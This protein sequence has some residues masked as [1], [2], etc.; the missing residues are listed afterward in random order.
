MASST[1]LLDLDLD[2][3]EQIISHLLNEGIE[4]MISLSLVSRRMR[5][6]ALP[7]V[8]RSVQW[9]KDR[10]Q[11]IP[12]AL[13]PYIKKLELMYKSDST[14]K[15]PSWVFQSQH[16]RCMELLSKA[17]PEMPNLVSF[18]YTPRLPPSLGFIKALA[19]TSSL[20]SL[21]IPTSF[22]IHDALILFRDL[23]GVRN[24]V[25]EQVGQATLYDA[26]ESKRALSVQCVANI[27]QGCSG[28]LEYLEIPGQ[29]CPLSDLSQKISLPVIRILVLTGFPPLESDSHNYP[30]WTIVQSMQKLNVLEVHCRLRII[31]ALPHRYELLPLNASQSQNDIFSSQLESIT[32]SNPSLS[33]QIFKRFPDSL[34]RLVLNFIPDSWQNMLQSGSDTVLAYHKPSMIV[35]LFRTLPSSRPN[36][37]QLCIRMGWCVTTGLLECIL[38]CFPGLREL[39][40]QGIR[41]FNRAEEPESDMAGIVVV[42]EKFESLHTL[43]LAVEFKED[44]YLET[45]TQARDI[46]SVETAMKGWANV[47]EEHIKSLRSLAF[48]KR[49]HTGKGYGRRAAIGTPQWVWFDINRET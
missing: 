9:P 26:P 30:L 11:L 37:E 17:L 32:I 34:K 44:S 46:G 41:Y 23:H 29:Y 12:S 35:G 4:N 20:Q 8:F 28:T 7:V 24:L 5:Q 22:L 47:L 48:E 45:S 40:L 27:V 38:Y 3:S 15:Q 49:R 1:N 19:S 6:H 13:W 43:K 16:G 36:L 33:D 21:Y 42:L 31:G 2:V 10:L 18:I 39:E 14:L 25:I